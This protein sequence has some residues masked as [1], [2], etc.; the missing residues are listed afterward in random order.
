MT[1]EDRLTRA[2]DAIFSGLSDGRG[3][4]L[5]VSGGVYYTLNHTGCDVWQALA[6]PT[7]PEE[8]S[9]SIADRYDVPRD[10]TAADVSPLLADLLSRG[11]IVSQRP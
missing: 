2:P 7:T 4:L 5:S 10:Q 6:A 11:L 3:V 1:S 9:R 8:I